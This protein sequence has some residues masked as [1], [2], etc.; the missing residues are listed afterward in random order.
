M[1]AH[2]ISSR[3]LNNEGGEEMKRTKSAV[4]AIIIA[5]TLTI[6]ASAFA[7]GTCK[8]TMGTCTGSGTM[9]PGSGT[10]TGK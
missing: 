10:M 4:V 8:C 2:I 7:M 1:T 3:D 9:V 5:L 6:G